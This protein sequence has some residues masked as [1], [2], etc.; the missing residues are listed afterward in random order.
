MWV[1]AY[2]MNDVLNSIFFPYF[3]KNNFF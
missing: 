2:V 1:N 3:Y